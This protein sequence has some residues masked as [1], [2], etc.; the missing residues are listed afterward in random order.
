VVVAAVAVAVA[1]VVVVVVVLIGSAAS[2]ST[3]DTPG[4]TDVSGVP[5]ALREPCEG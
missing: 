3:M 1:V 2:C 5:S 4:V